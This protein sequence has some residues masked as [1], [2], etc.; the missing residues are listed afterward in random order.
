M[1]YKLELVPIPV[2]D[3]DRA[4]ALR[5][6]RIELRE[7]SKALLARDALQASRQNGGLYSCMNWAWQP[8]QA[9]AARARGE[10]APSPA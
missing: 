6:E 1:D 3:V 4:K 9:G 2:A 7:E 10:A 8:S 5:G